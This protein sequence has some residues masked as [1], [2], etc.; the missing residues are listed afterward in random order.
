MGKESRGKRS[1]RR[2]IYRIFNKVLR[3]D[4]IF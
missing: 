4:R 3:I 2:G 1:G